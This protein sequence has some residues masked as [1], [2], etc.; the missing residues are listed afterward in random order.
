MTY[1]IAQLITDSSFH[2]IRT[3]LAENTIKTAL[4]D[5]TISTGRANKLTFM[6]ITWCRFIGSYIDNPLDDLYAEIHELRNAKSSRERPF[7]K[8]PVED[9]GTL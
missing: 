9:P 3:D 4:R 7:K 1:P 2:H 5:M 6:L 8:K